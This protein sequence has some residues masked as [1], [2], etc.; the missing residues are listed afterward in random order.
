MFYAVNT[1]EDE[2]HVPEFVAHEKW[3]I[4]VVFADSLDDFMTVATLPTVLLLDRSGKISFRVNG[5]PPEGFAESLTTAIQ[6]AL[7]PAK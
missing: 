5:F 7:A 1:D 3:D 4:P 6:D 2:A